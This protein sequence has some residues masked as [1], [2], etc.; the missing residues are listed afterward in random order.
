M[1]PE[2]LRQERGVRFGGETL[3]FVP[4]DQT[5]R[6]LR[7]NLL[8]EPLDVI[9]SRYIFVQRDTKPLRGKVLAA[10]PGQYP[11]VYL[12][13]NHDRL[14][15]WKRKERR[16][17]ASAKHFVPMSVKV[18]DVIELGGGEQEGYAFEVFIWGDRHVLW[19]TERDVC[20]IVS[21]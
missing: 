14:P 3:N 18:G 20:G 16:Y 21:E 15:D 9:Y 12:D 6:P 17:M 8:V 1:R 5:I 11:I 10:G 7:D 4:A 13:A 19:C 2:A